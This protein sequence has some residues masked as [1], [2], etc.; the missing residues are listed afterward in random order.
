MIKPFSRFVAP[1]TADQTFLD[2]VV[3]EFTGCLDQ[4]GAISSSPFPVSYIGANFQFIKPVRINATPAKNIVF[5]LLVE[6]DK[7]I[8]IIDISLIFVIGPQGVPQ[9]GVY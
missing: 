3:G 2:F 7:G 1:M 9:A 8:C 6:G 5:I 4:Q